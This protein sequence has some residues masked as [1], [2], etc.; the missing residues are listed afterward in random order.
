M[1]LTH[2]QIDGFCA[3]DALTHLLIE[4]FHS[5]TSTKGRFL[6]KKFGIFGLYV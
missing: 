5:N 6:H 2:I 3:I 1:Q 4:Y